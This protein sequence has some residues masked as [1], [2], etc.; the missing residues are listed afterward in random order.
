MAG[1]LCI[2]SFPTGVEY[3]Q[4]VR[5]SVLDY[6][7]GI[8]SAGKRHEWIAKDINFHYSHFGIARCNLVPFFRGNI[9]SG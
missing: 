4:S 2:F 1:T 7:H 9:L 3:S 5:V 6:L 8:G